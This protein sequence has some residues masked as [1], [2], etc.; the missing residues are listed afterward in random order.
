MKWEWGKGLENYHSK[1]EMFLE[2]KDFLTEHSFLMLLPIQNSLKL[3]LKSGSDIVGENSEGLVNLDNF[4][5]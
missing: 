4:N 1:I 3:S 5:S 2:I